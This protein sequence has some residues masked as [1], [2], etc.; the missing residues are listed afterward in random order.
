[1]PRRKTVSEEQLVE[2]LMLPPPRV[3]KHGHGHD[4]DPY[5]SLPG[6]VAVHTTIEPIKRKMTAGDIE[7]RKT[8]QLEVKAR[9]ER[10]ARYLDALA[11]HGG[12]QEQA[13]AE[14]YGLS[15]EQVRPRRLELQ[16]DVRSGLGATSLSD[17]LEQNDLALVARANLLRKHAYSANPAASLKALDMIGELEGERADVGSFESYLRLAKSSKG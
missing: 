16:M 14:V 3:T 15:V 9:G 11:E 10:Y 5:Q 2:P 8:A 17:V 6:A 7:A 12:D 1:M 4:V 13:L